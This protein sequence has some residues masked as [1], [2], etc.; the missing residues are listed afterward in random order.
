L[1]GPQ[2]KALQKIYDGPRNPRTGAR[3]YPGFP[4]T[5]E[6]GWVGFLTEAPGGKGLFLDTPFSLFS[7]NLHYRQIFDD[8]TWDARRFDF[9]ADLAFAE[10]KIV[11]GQKMKAIWNAVDD[12]VSRL[13]DRGA[14]ILMYVGWGDQALSPLEAIAYYDDIV[15]AMGDRTEKFFRL[16]MVPGMY[17]C[18]GGPG[19]NAFG[20]T[21][22]P[23]PEA[24]RNDRKH[25]IARALE[26]WV[27]DSR[28]PDSITAAKYVDDR[29]EKGLAFT[30]PLCAYPQIAVYK[31]DAAGSESSFACES[32]ASE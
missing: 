13:Y 3:I 16:F 21:F 6:L 10:N 4:P 27:E 28:A 22:L 23:A 29:P 26:G 32:P 14:K 17:H 25:H 9:D 5:M 12:D 2:A 19:A 1:T 8:P 11:G 31:P 18:G 24:L 20:Q 7:A 15:R 30:S